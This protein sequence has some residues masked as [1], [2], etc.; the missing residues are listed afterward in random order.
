MIAFLKDFYSGNIENLT[1]HDIGSSTGII[2]SVLSK[3]FGKVVG[4]DIDRPAVESGANQFRDRNISFS[5]V[6][7]FQYIWLLRKTNSG[8]IEMS[9]CLAAFLFEKVIP[10]NTSKSPNAVGPVDFFALVIGPPLITDRNLVNPQIFFCYLGRNLGFKTES[11]FLYCN[12]FQRL[13]GKCFVAG[14]HISGINVVK[15]I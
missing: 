11:V 14:F 3:N 13:T 1:V 7:C 8:C 15:N 4:I 10:Q 12:S 9:N 2:A 5:V 6:V